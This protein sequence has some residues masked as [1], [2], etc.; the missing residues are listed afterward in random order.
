[1]DQKDQ[2]LIAPKIAIRIVIVNQKEPCC[3]GEKSFLPL[4]EIWRRCLPDIIEEEAH[5][6]SR[7]LYA[8]IVPTVVIVPRFQTAGQLLM[9]TFDDF[10]K[11]YIVF[12]ARG[13]YDIAKRFRYDFPGLSVVVFVG[14]AGLGQKVDENHIVLISRTPRH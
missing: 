14:D 1:M 4:S 8:P 6:I 3:S 2:K 9:E 13:M 12:V 10:A 11:N 7:E 5:R